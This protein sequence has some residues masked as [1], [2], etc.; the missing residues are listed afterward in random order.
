MV[1]D[2]EAGNG[3]RNVSRGRRLPQAVASASAL[4]RVDTPEA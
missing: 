2:L 3:P 4:P 1:S